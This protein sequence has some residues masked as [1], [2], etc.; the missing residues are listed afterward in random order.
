MPQ[1]VMEKHLQTGI[2]ILLV[3]LILW[4]GNT[5]LELR[6]KVA[7]MEEQLRSLQTTSLAATADGYTRSQA[8][9]ELGELRRRIESV[10]RNTE[11][12]H[13]TM[14]E[15]ISSLRDRQARME[16]NRAPGK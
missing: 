2:Q 11:K 16:Q 6:D 10:E 9:S 7:R 14:R 8:Q 1:P 13:A 4:S 12:E 5:T 15:L 3:A